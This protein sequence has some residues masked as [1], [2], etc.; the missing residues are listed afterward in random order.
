MHVRNAALLHQTKEI[1]AERLAADAEE[2][3]MRRDVL[4]ETLKQ[5]EQARHLHAAR[6][7]V[8]LRDFTNSFQ[9]ES[10]RTPGPSEYAPLSEFNRAAI[11]GA[12]STQQS[13][14][15]FDSV[16]RISSGTPGPASYSD[17]NITAVKPKKGNPTF[18]HDTH[19]WLDTHQR[20]LTS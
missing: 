1:E 11:G 10:K 3:D 8:M 13:G 17:T 14:T 4:Q 15:M 5:A 2:K 18:A 9:R 16:S 7:S 6:E 20:M 12:F 19:T